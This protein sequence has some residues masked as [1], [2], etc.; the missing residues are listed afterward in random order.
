MSDV[1][2][3]GGG[4]PLAHIS[5]TPDDE[6]NLKGLARFARLAGV[7]AIVSASLQGIAQVLT[8]V[9]REGHD[10]AG[11]VCGG[12]VAM[13]IAGVL[14]LFLF[15]VSRAV[16]RVARTGDADPASLVAALGSLA[17]YFMVKGMLYIV[18]IVLGC[19]CV[20]TLLVFGSAIVSAMGGA[21]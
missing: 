11:A 9:M 8:A 1:D 7:A 10:V 19:L 2:R 12:A 16:D 15:R 5:F 21:V 18:V 13:A 6:R 17:G 4:A 14:A 3:D 20:G